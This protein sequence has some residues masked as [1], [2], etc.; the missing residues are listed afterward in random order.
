VPRDLSR[1]PRAP[2]SSGPLRAPCPCA[3][4]KIGGRILANIADFN[5]ICLDPGF[6]LIRRVPSMGNCRAAG[7]RDF[8]TAAAGLDGYVMR[9]FY[10]PLPEKVEVVEN[11]IQS[12]FPFSNSLFY[13][14]F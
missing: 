4:P 6:S 9:S 3:V 1:L 2:N 7:F 10:R 12:K 11:L 5:A 8:H 14:L 13:T